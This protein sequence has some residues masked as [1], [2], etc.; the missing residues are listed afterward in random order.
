MNPKSYKKK[1]DKQHEFFFGVNPIFLLIETLE[2][3]YFQ[4]KRKKRQ[5][6]VHKKY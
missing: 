1:T 5:D 4:K 2:L 3:V 6:L